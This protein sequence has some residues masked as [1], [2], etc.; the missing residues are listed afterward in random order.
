MSY[1]L[2]TYKKILLLTNAHLEGYQRV[3]VINVS[4]GKIS[5]KT[6]PPFSRC[7]KA[8]V[9]NRG[10]VVHGTNT[11]MTANALYYNPAKPSASSTL[12]KIAAVLPKKNKSEVRTS[13]E[14]QETHTKHRPV[15]KPFLHNPNTVS[16][17]MGVGE[18]DLLDVQYLRIYNDMHK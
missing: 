18:C 12:D 13:L 11:K 15:R 9:S 5:A 1:D 3:G 7:P 16:N 6:S 10:Y 8:D 17:L 4:G 14:Q 2:R